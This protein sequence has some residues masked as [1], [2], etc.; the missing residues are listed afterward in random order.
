MNRLP[1]ANPPAL[2]YLVSSFAYLYLNNKADSLRS[3][4]YVLTAVKLRQRFSFSILI[5]AI[6]A[7]FAARQDAMRND[8]TLKKKG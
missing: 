6:N 3:Q 4:A 1:R 2:L 7:L 8:D 5:T